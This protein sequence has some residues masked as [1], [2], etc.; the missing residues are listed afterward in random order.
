MRIYVI[1]GNNKKIVIIYIRDKIVLK[2]VI[3]YKRRYLKYWKRILK[4]DSYLY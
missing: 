1:M 3:N 4:T 2:K